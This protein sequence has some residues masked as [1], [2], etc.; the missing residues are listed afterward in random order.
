MDPISTI[1]IAKDSTFAM[2]LEAQRRGWDLW[3][4]EQ[5]DLQLLNGVPSATMRRLRVTDDPAGWFEF[6]EV[7]E[8]PLGE[9]DALLMRKDPPFDMEYVYTTYLLEQAEARGCL[10]V[11]RPAALRD[12]N[13]KLYTA[14]FPACC[15]PTLVARREI[16]LRAFLAE[17]G[18]I[19]VKPLGGMGGAS[20]FRVTDTDPNTGVILET[21]TDH[22]RRYAMA[23][24]FIP[25][26]SAGDK[27]ILVVGGEAVP[28]ALAR[29]PK[30]GET[31]GNLAAGGT[32]HGVPL[33]ERDRWIV[34]QVAPRLVEAGILFAGLD[35][36]GDYLTEINV[37]SPTCIRELDA[38][39]NLN[40]SGILMDR[41]EEQLAV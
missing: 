30:S 38:I 25:E 19:I 2:L 18:D 9:L 31:R 37:T 21:L 12:A 24:K 10:V 11:N 27:R 33:S 15:P 20:V 36:I 39:Y 29:V 8:G 1:K 32:G 14:W 16:T 23:Q 40:I 5:P 34:A 6:E 41:I 22:G 3:Y 17:H 4:M 13:E 7:Q 28:Y 26:I 35:V